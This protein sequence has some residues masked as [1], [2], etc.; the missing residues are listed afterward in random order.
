MEAQ[1]RSL[2]FCSLYVCVCLCVDVGVLDKAVSFL[3][4]DMSGMSVK[5]LLHMSIYMQSASQER[6]AW[7]L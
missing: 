2:T 4:V 3:H 6:E 7:M 5:C 1:V